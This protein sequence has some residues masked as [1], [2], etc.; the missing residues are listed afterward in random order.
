[1][2][3]TTSDSW[4]VIPPISMDSLAPP[5]MAARAST[6]ISMPMPAAAYSQ[7]QF[8]RD[9]TLRMSTGTTRDRAVPATMIRYCFLALSKFSLD[10]IINP[11]VINIHIL[12][13]SSMLAFR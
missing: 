9:L 7:V 11:M 8:F 2:I 13:T 6:T 3:F 1:M 5:L 12:F 4:K 10:I